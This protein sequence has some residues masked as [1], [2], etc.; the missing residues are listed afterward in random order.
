MSEASA[1]SAAGR[2]REP[3]VQRWL[4]RGLG[5]IAAVVLFFMMALTLV[6]VLGRYLFD[7]PIPGGFEMTEVALATLIFAGLPLVTGREEH[8]TVDLFDRLIPAGVRPVRDALIS[9]LAGVVVAMI[10]YHVWLK[11]LESRQ[12]GDITATIHIPLWPLVVFMSVS[13][14]GTA[15][16]YLVLA[17]RRLAWGDRARS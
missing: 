4:R 6:D 10:G 16:V 8:V 13:L 2:T 11:A 5:G 12:Y 15:V 14:F 3:P 9:L 17:W 7:W 1:S